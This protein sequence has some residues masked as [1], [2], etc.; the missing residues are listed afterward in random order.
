MADDT[1]KRGRRDR[2]HININEKYEREYW[3]GK[4]GVSEDELREAVE[5][6][7]PSAKAVEQELRKKAS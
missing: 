5:R 3:T 6:V 4:F 1:S 2:T 7:G